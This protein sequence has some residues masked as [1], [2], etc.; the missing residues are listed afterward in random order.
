MTQPAEK[1][2]TAFVRRGVDALALYVPV[3]LFLS[4]SGGCHPTLPDTS[5]L[6]L[7]RHK[8]SFLPG[9]SY[10]GLHTLEPVEEC[11]YKIVPFSVSTED[12]KKVSNIVRIVCS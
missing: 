7:L 6:K 10:V 11:K 8:S 12:L 9:C 3:S 1:I 5:E 4:T 2:S